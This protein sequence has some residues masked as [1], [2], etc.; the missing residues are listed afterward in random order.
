MEKET[1]RP[2][3]ARYP[4]DAMLQD[5]QDIIP[6][7]EAI[8]R[9]DV[10]DDVGTLFVEIRDGEYGRVYFVKTTV[11]YLDSP[12]TWLLRL[13]DLDADGNLRPDVRGIPNRD[14]DL[15]RDM[16]AMGRKRAA[17]VLRDLDTRERIYVGEKF[18]PELRSATE[19]WM[20]RTYGVRTPGTFEEARNEHFRLW[21]EH[22]KK[23]DTRRMLEQWM[24][25]TYGTPGGTIEDA[26]AEYNRIW[27][28]AGD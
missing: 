21:A 13:T 22:R 15:D 27:P 19:R 25:D 28:P 5:E 20:L 4:D 11:P 18:S 7:L 8:G 16:Q 9:M 10:L 12:V 17:E 1:L 2:V 3:E 26:Q 23:E 14:W 24:M 6:V